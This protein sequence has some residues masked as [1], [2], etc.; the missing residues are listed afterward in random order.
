M[1]VETVPELP[2]FLRPLLPF[3]RRAYR[4]EA[5]PHAGDILHLV[6]T[7]VASDDGE[8]AGKKSSGRESRPGPPA[9]WLMHG[10]PTWS[11][12]WR[13][14]IPRLGGLRVIAPDMLGL[15]LSHKPAKVADHS[16]LDHAEALSELFAALELE[17]VVLVG[18]DWGGPMVTSIGRRHPEAVAGLVFLNTAVA[19][20]S[21]PRGT[22]FHRFAKMPVISDLVFRGLGFPLRVLHRTQGDPSTLRGTV[23]RAYRWPLRRRSERAAPLAL[24]RMVP[25]SPDHPSLPE[26]RAAEAWVSAYEGPISLVW[27]ERDPILGRALRRHL[28]RFP[29]ATVRRCNAGHFLQEEVP[30]L[31]AEAIRELVDGLEDSPDS[32][33]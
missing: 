28:E 21:R 30:E 18:Q 27:G 2:P 33:S 14:V 24:A 20:P 15:G 11:F 17:R 12:L 1:F 4:L 10:N 5:G 25:D 29:H 6:D 7:V 13:K 22:A 32:K 26:M 9:I 16:V 31:I 3:D 8:P 23:A 19:L